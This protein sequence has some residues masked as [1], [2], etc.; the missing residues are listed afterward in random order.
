MIGMSTRTGQICSRE[1][2]M[3]T[4]ILFILLVICPSL[5]VGIFYHL[6]TKNLNADNVIETKKRDKNSNSS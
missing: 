4:W 6:K 2:R 1:V 3:I 5:V